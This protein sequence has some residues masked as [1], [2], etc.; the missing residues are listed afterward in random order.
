ME[1]EVFTAIDFQLLE[2][3]FVLYGKLKFVALHAITCAGFSEALLNELALI[4]LEHIALI[5]GLVQITRLD[6]FA[7]DEEV[8][9]IYPATKEKNH[10]QGQKDKESFFHRLRFFRLITSCWVKGRQWPRGRSF[11]VSPAK[12]TL[13]SFSTV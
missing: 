6:S 11:L 9:H 3:T 1:V 8:S 7:K 2:Y 12:A 10:Q 5:D 13:S 4:G